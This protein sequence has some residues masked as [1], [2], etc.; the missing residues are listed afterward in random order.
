[1]P[2]HGLG[3]G[4]DA[5]G[6]LP[7]ATLA[8]TLC[9]AEDNQPRSFSFRLTEKLTSQVIKV[10]VEEPKKEQWQAELEI[11]VRC[12]PTVHVTVAILDQDDL[13][14]QVVFRRFTAS[15]GTMTRLLDRNDGL[16]II[17]SA[18]SP[19]N[20]TVKVTALGEEEPKPAP[21]PAAQAGLKFWDTSDPKNDDH[22][23]D[24]PFVVRYWY[25][26][27]P[28]PLPDGRHRIRRRPRAPR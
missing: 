13:K 5:S 27:A 21:D 23:P 7:A 8:A 19:A 18:T 16:Y 3:S 24:S 28:H 6:P 17:A 10:Q 26:D 12:P 4:H 20:V 9:V 15:P 1:M 14:S 11:A 25:L 22:F 2:R